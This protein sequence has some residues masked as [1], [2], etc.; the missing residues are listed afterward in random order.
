MFRP[1]KARFLKACCKQ[2]GVGALCNVRYATLTLLYTARF[3]I[4]AV[5]LGINF[6]PSDAN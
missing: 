6:S 2:L 5:L 3:N 4:S 1:E